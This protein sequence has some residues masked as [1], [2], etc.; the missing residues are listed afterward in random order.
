MKKYS[1]ILLVLFLSGCNLWTNFTTYFNVYYNTID[2]FDEAETLIKEQKRDLFATT[3]LNVPSGANANLNKVVEKCSRILQF[4]AESGFVDDA[5][6]IIGKSFYYQKNYLKAIRKFQELLATQQESDLLLE[7]ELWIGKCQMKLREENKGLETLKSVRSKAIEEDEYEIIK[8][9][10][11]E[12]IVYYIFREDNQLALTLLNEFLEVSDDDV[13]NAE[14]VYQAGKLYLIEKDVQNAI[15][16]FEKVFDYS[17]SYDIEQD[18]N[19]QLGL[20]LREGDEKEKALEIFEQM[21]DEDKY[22]LAYDIIDLEIGITLY[23]LGRLEEAVD[24]LSIVDTSY[25]NFTSSGAA[26]YVLGEIY[27]NSFNNYDSASVYYTKASSSLAPDEYKTLALDKSKLFKKYETLR[28]SID[29]QEKQLFYLKYPE[30]FTKDSLAYVEDSLLYVADSLKN[31]DVS[32]LFQLPKDTSVIDPML[33]DSTMFDSTLTDTSLIN[34][35][36]ADSILRYNFVQDSLRNLRPIVKRGDERGGQ[37]I[38]TTTPTNEKPKLNRP[39]KTN[40]PPDS[41]KTLV[42]KDQLELGNLFLSELHRSDSAYFYYN[43][44]LTE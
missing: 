23:E 14:I 37:D 18:A 35:A 44:I 36:K 17:P 43:N 5:L 38:T 21:R 34:K 13:I 11:V 29:A 15:I 1:F 3:E 8:A 39:I 25:T 27:E 30:E 12:E 42:A 9:S 19:I 24:Q 32:H 2:L 4:G 33:T 26:R 40:I 20:A 10:Y 41:I 7:T 16:A 31:V 6:L 22:S 28:T